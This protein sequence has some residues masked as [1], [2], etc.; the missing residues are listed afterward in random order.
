MAQRLDRLH[1]D[2][3]SIFQ[4]GEKFCYGI[5]AVLLA[6]FALRGA[7]AVKG[8]SSVEG[9]ASGKEQSAVKGG[10]KNGRSFRF[11]DLGC[12]N[13]IIPIL[14]AA[15]TSGDVKITGIEIQPDVAAMARR[16]VEINGLEGRI[17]VLEGDIKNIAAEF[18][19]GCA[20]AVV[21]NPPY[22]LV[23]EGRQSSNFSRMAARQEI[24][25]C[26][27]DVVRAADFLLAEGG[28]FFMIHRPQRLEEIFALLEKFRFGKVFWREVKPLESRDATMVLVRAEKRWGQ[29]GW[30]EGSALEKCRLEDLVIYES[31]SPRRYTAE[32]FEIYGRKNQ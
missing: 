6:D 7:S 11:F 3:F 18:E 19:K 24:L 25:C 1:I 12:G 13:G 14:L 27:E 2:G 15:K 31:S 16:S 17:E 23:S 21:S 28:Q 20:D 30:Q 29:D 4:D 5:D 22:M 10:G 26:L 8:A 32:V 9:E